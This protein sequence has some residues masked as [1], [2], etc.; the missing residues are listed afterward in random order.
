MTSTIDQYKIIKIVGTGAYG[1]V[2]KAMHIPTNTI[3]ALKSIKMQNDSS[4][5]HMQLIMLA[6]EMQILFKLSRQENNQFTVALLDA[7]VNKE[8]EE[9][10]KELTKIYLVMEYYEFDMMK[11]L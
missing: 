11:L 3:V 5:L 2:Y 10:F 4:S 9:N 1:K 8:A 6:R 7:F